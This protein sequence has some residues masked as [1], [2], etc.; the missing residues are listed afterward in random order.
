ML[1]GTIVRGELGGR[2]RVHAAMTEVLDELG[3]RRTLIKVGLEYPVGTGGSRLSE[4]QR[5][6]LA[7]ANAILKRPDILALYDATAVLDSAAETSI[8]ER[9]KAEFAERSLILKGS[10][11][12][13]RIGANSSPLPPHP[14]PSPPARGRGAGVRGLGIQETPDELVIDTD[15]LEAKIR[16]KGYVSGLA[17]GSLLDKKTGARDAGFGLHI[18][19]F[20][21]GPGW[22]DDGYSRYKKHHGDLPKHY[23][24]GPQICTQAKELTPQ[25]TRGEDFVAVRL[26]FR[27]TQPAKGYKAPQSND[28]DLDDRGLIYLIDRENGLDILELS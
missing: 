13:Y 6:K 12:L 3:L 14:Y 5:Q 7:I 20:L 17:A 28:V 2:E 4:A 23:V 24:E 10:K 9:L 16:K 22:R 27:F 11:F 18:M 15:C 26:R 21:L 1:F 25:V 19:D 8:L